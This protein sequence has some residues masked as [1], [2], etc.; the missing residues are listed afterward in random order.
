ML[1]LLVQ[2][3]QK[4]K[5]NKDQEIQEKQLALKLVVKKMLSYVLFVKNSLIHLIRTAN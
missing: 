3:E 2:L 1:L 5:Q 4:I